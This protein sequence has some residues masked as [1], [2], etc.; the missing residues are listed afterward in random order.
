MI[1]FAVVGCSST[2]RFEQLGRQLRALI[3]SMHFTQVSFLLANVFFL[4]MGC[5]IDAIRSC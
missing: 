4:V 3:A 2:S 1:I 5:I